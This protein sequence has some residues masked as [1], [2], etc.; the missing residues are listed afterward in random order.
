MMDGREAGFGEK[1]NG[2]NSGRRG[3]SPRRSFWRW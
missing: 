1:S 2:E 3:Y